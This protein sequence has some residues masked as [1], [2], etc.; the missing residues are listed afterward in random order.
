MNI[1]GFEIKR[2]DSSPAIASVTSPITDDGSTVVSSSATSYYGMVMDMDATIKNENELIRRYRE[3]ALYMDCDSA[4]E[5][6]VNES[7]IAESD[8]QSV[9]INLDKVK[10]SEPIKKKI[11]NEFDEIL[12]LLDFERK[13]HDIFR[14]WYIDGRN[15]YNV[16]VDPKQPKLGIQ[17]LRII[18][19][20]KIRKIKEVEKKRTDK[21][22]DI[23]IDKAEYYIYNDKGITESAVNGIKMSLDSVVYTPSGSVDQG[24]GMMMSYLHKAIKPTNQLKMIEDAVVIYR[25]SRAPE[26]RVFYVDVGNL[27][28][29]KAEQYVNDIMNKFRN[30]IVYDATTGETRDDRRHLSM[31]E[32]FWMPRREGGKGTEITT[33]PGG[34]NLGDIADIQYFQRKLYQALNVPMSRL[35]SSSGFALG[36]STEISRDEIKFMKFI[37]RLRKKFSSM[38]SGCLKVQLIAKGIL[39]IEDWEAIEQAVQYDF[40]QDNHF[41]E[42][43]DN[44]LMIQR[45]TALQQLDPYIGRYY[46]SKWVRKNVLMQ[47]DEEI[48]EMDKEMELDK[49]K[50][51]DDA[52]Q[53]GTIAG[54]TQ[55]AQQQHLMDNGMGGDEDS[56]NPEQGDKK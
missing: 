48:S 37:S 10:L 27:P 23:S 42:L 2:K 33:L 1:L 28:K 39:T 21:G 31:M 13:G 3:T 4:I 25:I 17:E 9:K 47:T 15:Y 51:L 30:K 55:V 24:T 7:I 36:R 14:Q 8:D 20:R 18:D 34:Q 6:I 45:I 44:E 38:F 50:A 12:R 53:Q 32:D 29:L 35:E 56:P 46:S 52:A 54:V 5:D 19:P 49:Q 41:A 22:V 26:R 43:K 40:Q 11:I 16:L